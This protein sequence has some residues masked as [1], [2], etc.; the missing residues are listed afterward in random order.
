MVLISPLTKPI[1]RHPVADDAHAHTPE[2]TARIL[3]KLILRDLPTSQS[4]QPPGGGLSTPG[5]NTSP[6]HGKS[7]PLGGG[8]SDDSDVDHA[9]GAS[10]KP[11]RGRMGSK[12]TTESERGKGQVI[13]I[14]WDKRMEAMSKEKAE[15]EARAG[16]C[17]A[18]S[19]PM[20]LVFRAGNPR[21]LTHSYT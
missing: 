9:L 18:Q 1:I 12:R 11:L 5:I 21:M 7:R 16:T 20:S 4:Q 10:L 8:D 15:T 17:S 19:S 14:E 2:Y 3:E 13:T 6:M